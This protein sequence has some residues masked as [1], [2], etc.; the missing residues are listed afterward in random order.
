MLPLTT[1]LVLAVPVPADVPAAQALRAKYDQ[2]A[3]P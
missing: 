3:A 2:S 1:E